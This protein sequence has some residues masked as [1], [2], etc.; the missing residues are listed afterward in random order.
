MALKGTIKQDTR[1]KQASLFGHQGKRGAQHAIEH[2]EPHPGQGCDQRSV[3][4]ADDHA[5]NLARA[6]AWDPM[7]VG[8]WQERL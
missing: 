3:L 6:D 1:P 5:G 4:R 8:A 7:H 2:T